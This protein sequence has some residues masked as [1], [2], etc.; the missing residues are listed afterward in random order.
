LQARLEAEPV[1]DPGAGNQDAVA[2]FML[3]AVIEHSD[4][5]IARA[6]SKDLP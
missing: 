3:F 6:M 5:A 2:R 1:T 4:T